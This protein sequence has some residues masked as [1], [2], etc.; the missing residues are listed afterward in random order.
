MSP[1]SVPG[2]GELAVLKEQVSDRSTVKTP[3]SRR[4]F[5]FLRVQILTINSICCHSYFFR[6]P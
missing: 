3:I 5:R 1:R 4:I 6:A 2:A